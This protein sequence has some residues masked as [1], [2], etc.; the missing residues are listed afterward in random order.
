MEI[1]QQ[2]LRPSFRFVQLLQHQ[3][4]HEE[5]GHQEERV[6]GQRRPEDHHHC[7][8]IVNLELIKRVLKAL[9]KKLHFKFKKYI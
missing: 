3:V 8:V 2:D 7:T 1:G 9:D 4:G 5:S 6:H